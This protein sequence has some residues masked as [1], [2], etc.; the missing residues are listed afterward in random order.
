MPIVLPEMMY[1]I[2][3]I[4]LNRTIIEGESFVDYQLTFR[5]QTFIKRSFCLGGTTGMNLGLSLHKF[6]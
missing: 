6:L 4:I 3:E 5:L 2:Y 1:T